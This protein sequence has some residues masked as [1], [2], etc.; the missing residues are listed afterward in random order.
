MPPLIANA[1]GKAE[2]SMR[3]TISAGCFP[4]RSAKVRFKDGKVVLTDFRFYPNR[5]PRLSE[6]LVAFCIGGKWG[7]CDK[8]GNIALPARYE[9]APE[10]H[11]GL[12]GVAEGGNYGFINKQGKWIIKPAFDATYRW[13]FIG[14]VC[15]VS[16]NGKYAVINRKGQFVWPPGLV[17]AENLG[18]GI[19]IRTASGRSGFLTNSGKLIANSKPN[20]LYYRENENTR[21]IRLLT[22]Q[23]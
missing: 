13:H 7:A 17:Q 16:H 12:A 21:R 10:F 20:P 22:G 1:P 9:S 23:D 11:E 4:D 18:G 6:G 15:A 2:V 5:E 3:F 19:F 8:H 14:E